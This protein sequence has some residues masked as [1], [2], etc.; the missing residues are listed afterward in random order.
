MGLQVPVVTLDL[1]ANLDDL[2]TLAHLDHPVQ[3]EKE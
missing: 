2:V 1:M 3:L